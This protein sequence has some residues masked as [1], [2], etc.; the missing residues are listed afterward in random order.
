MAKA[1]TTDIYEINTLNVDCLKKA[2]LQYCFT[3]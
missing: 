1:S 3:V 2:F